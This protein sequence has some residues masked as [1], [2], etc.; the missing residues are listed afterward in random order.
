MTGAEFSEVDIDLLADYV[1][2]A[3]D[4]TP[5]EVLV[6]NL[7]AENP[8]WRDA[9]AQLSGGVAAVT[10]QL[11]ALGSVA[12][13][14]PAEVFAR[15][16][17]ALTA[18]AADEGGGTVTSIADSSSGVTA[19]RAAMEPGTDGAAPDRHL[20]AV[21]SGSRGRRARRLRWAAPVGIAAGVLAFLGFG[22][23]QLSGAD[24][25][26]T[27]AAGSAAEAP[28]ANSGQELGA[29]GAAPQILESGTDYRRDTLGSAGMTT[30]LDQPPARDSST[31]ARKALPDVGASAE[32]AAG[33]D[34]AFARLRAQE[35]LR[36]C[37]EAIAAQHG[38]GPIT[39]QTIDY[40]RFD[41]RPAVIVQFVADG[42]SWV[43]AVGP[44]CGTRGVG[45]DTRASVKVG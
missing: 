31:D 4:G 30:M 1:G 19:G 17:S 12:E 6:T 41:G 27:S 42:E 40:A 2:G 7:I 22:F 13:P 29:P 20:V 10:G 44:A 26:D 45:A 32:V 35:A 18:A 15:I 8:A 33:A 28:R 24:S 39:P 36:A 9:H 11:R 5:D 14:M 38:V 37:I 25:A 3:L 43:W 23:Q 16:D 34:P 21:P